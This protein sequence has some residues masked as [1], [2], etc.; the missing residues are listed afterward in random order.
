LKKAQGL[1][2]GLFA[3]CFAGLAAR[4]AGAPLPDWSVRVAGVGLMI[5]VFLLT[6]TTVRLRITKR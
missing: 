5:A 6:F 3:V 2:I 1:S 4:W